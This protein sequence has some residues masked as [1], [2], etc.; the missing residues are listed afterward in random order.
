MTRL[1]KGL[2]ASIVTALFGVAV[3]AE[4]VG[5]PPRDQDESV[6]ACH[7]REL[8]D[9]SLEAEP[10]SVPIP[11]SASTTV[12]WEAQQGVQAVRGINIDA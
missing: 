4:T 1:L 9:H 8:P 5:T 11:V 12:S 6:S 3:F 10:P 7:H 2:L